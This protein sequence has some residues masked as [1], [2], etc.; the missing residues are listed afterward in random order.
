SRARVSRRG[1]ACR[2]TRPSRSGRRLPG[3]A[4]SSRRRP[5]DRHRRHR[6]ARGRDDSPRTV[7]TRVHRAPRDAA[8]VS[9]RDPETEAESSSASEDLDPASYEYWRASGYRG[10]PPWRRGYRWGYFAIW[11]ALVALL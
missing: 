8:A 9:R 6:L 11:L 10:R 3:R 1:S 5:G 7:A 2:A 4:R